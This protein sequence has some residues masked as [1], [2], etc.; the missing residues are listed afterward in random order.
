MF[1]YFLLTILNTYNIYISYILV[2]KENMI[3]PVAHILYQFQSPIHWLY[4]FILQHYNCCY[5]RARRAT[6]QQPQ[7]EEKASGPDQV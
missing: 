2:D 6:V 1:V 5:Y 4:L 3:I 7:L